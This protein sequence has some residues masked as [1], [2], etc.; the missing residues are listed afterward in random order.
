MSPRAH[1]MSDTETRTKHIA[2]PTATHLASQPPTVS[3]SRAAHIHGIWSGL[4]LTTVIAG[5]A[6][7]L[8][9][10]LGVSSLS[11]LIIAILLGIAF[12]NLIGTPQRAKAGVTFS[13]RRILRIAIMLLG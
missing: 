5:G 9:Q 6:F 1:R 4:V 12:H 11:P 10:I 13:L 3:R 8:R 2:L 7:A